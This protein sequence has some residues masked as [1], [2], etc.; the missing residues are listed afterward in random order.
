MT[1]GEVRDSLGAYALGALEPA[2]AAAVRDHLAGCPECQAA[3]AELAGIPDL[4]GLLRLEEVEQGVV[5]PDELGLQRLLG[6]VRAER[7]RD[8][9]RRL[10][11]ALVA[12]ALVVIVA[13]GGGWAVAHWQGETAP[14]VA[15]QSP[16]PTTPTPAPT[17]TTP[18]PTP[19]LTA[20]PVHWSATS[21]DETVDA[22]ATM[23]GVPWGTK[24][25]IVLHGVKKGEVCSLVVWD[26]SGRRWDGGSWR[27]AYAQGVRWSG[28]IAVPAGEVE[29]I[30]IFA[31]GE[32]PLLTMDS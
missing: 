16:T 10:R 18:A 12:A 6:R 9:R 31:P 1:C 20:A 3:Q 5:E 8:R 24:V 23:N 25:D 7:G 22:T 14:V 13:G 4:L 21:A 27:V 32:R 17:P 26:R 29:R 15:Q 11:A 30:Q 28:G 2:E 19:R